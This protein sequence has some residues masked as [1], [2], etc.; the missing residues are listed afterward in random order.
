MDETSDSNGNPNALPLSAEQVLALQNEIE[1]LK[2]RLLTETEQGQADRDA[3]RQSAERVKELESALVT[4]ETA[5]ARAA[6]KLSTAGRANEELTTE[7]A[8]VRLGKAKA[9]RKLRQVRRDA[10]ELTQQLMSAKRKV[11]RVVKQLDYA[12]SEVAERDRQLVA[13]KVSPGSQLVLQ[14]LVR[15]WLVSKRGRRSLRL[16]PTVVTTGNGPLSEA[17]VRATLAGH[18]LEA[19]LPAVPFSDVMVVGRDGWLV[20][21]LEEQIRVRGEDGV[22]VYS[23]EMLLAALSTNDDPLKSASRKTLMQ[24]AE[25]H[26]ALTYLIDSG[27]EWPVVTWRPL[28]EMVEFEK[29]EFAEQSPINKLGYV[30]GKVKGLADQP[31][32]DLL[33]RA[34]RGKVPNVVSSRYMKSWGEPGSR[35]RLRRIARH[36]A[37]LGSLWR[38]QDT[39]VVAV[40]HW[41]DDLDWMREHLYEPWMRFRWPEIGA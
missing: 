1:S 28:Q 5:A 25:G 22:R 38:Y 31:R 40:E 36:I 29:G 34:F 13:L 35:V 11:A 2:A 17:E 37:W 7:L 39:H 6:R 8:Q 27:F 26:P 14:P 4:T 9:L 16:P 33:A 3:A 10:T 18:G 21:D 15:E 20:D 41:S 24:F 32:R 23:Q 30:V 12:V 19:K